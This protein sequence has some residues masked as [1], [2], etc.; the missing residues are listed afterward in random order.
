MEELDK[1]N[2]PKHIAIVLDGNRRW[3]KANGLTT[4][5]GHVAGA[6]NLERIAKFCHD[7]GIK[8]LTVYCFS[9]E[10]WKRSKEEID[11]LMLIFSGYLNSFAKNKSI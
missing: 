1:E 6:K 4:K 7:I 10:N 9:T 8:H 5:E 2:L 3:A 11:A